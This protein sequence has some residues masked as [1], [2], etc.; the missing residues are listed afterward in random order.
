MEP[1]SLLGSLLGTNAI[2]AKT[3]QH[4]IE[5]VIAALHNGRYD[6]IDEFE[7]KV[8]LLLN[9]SIEQIKRY[10]EEDEKGKIEMLTSYI[11][12]FFAYH[13]FDRLEDA[14]I[15]KEELDDILKDLALE[16]KALPN[17]A[18]SV[19][20]FFR[21]LL[22]SDVAIDY[23]VMGDASEE[24]DLE[25]Q[26]AE[27]RRHITQLIAEDSPKSREEVK[28]LLSYL[29]KLVH[30][31]FHALCDAETEVEIQEADL[32]HEIN[33]IAAK[34]SQGDKERLLQIRQK[35]EDHCSNDILEAKRLY[36]QAEKLRDELEHR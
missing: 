11:K 30:R 13:V 33:T 5:E 2:T 21:H 20:Y 12:Q 27:T 10:A 7:Q 35:I 25:E 17:E 14:T 19:H 28:D 6:R 26:E 29:V 23:R 31:E 36:S 32:I 1:V 18:H 9:G 34:A 4:D 24:I 16:E 15:L 8:D 3:E 22:H